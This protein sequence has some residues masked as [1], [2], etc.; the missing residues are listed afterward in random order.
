MNK[1]R[2][3][4]KEQGFHF[5]PVFLAV[6]VCSEVVGSCPFELPCLVRD[7][8]TICTLSSTSPYLSRPLKT[9]TRTHWLQ[10]YYSKWRMFRVE[11]MLGKGGWC[12]WSSKLCRQTRVWLEAAK[13]G[14]FLPSLPGMVWLVLAMSSYQITVLPGLLA[15]IKGS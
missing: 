8:Q 4:L 15:C 9:A 6:G 10:T 7:P 5:F 1:E 13:Q 3:F 14:V 11:P 2:D 12:S